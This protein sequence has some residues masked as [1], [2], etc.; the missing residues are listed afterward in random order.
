MYDSH[1]SCN[2]IDADGVSLI[3]AVHFNISHPISF[4]ER[5]AS[6]NVYMR[7]FRRIE[8]G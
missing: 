6:E 2:V 7:V 8:K 1:A 4:I 3:C 5:E